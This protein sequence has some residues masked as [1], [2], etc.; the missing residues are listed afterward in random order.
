MPPVLQK[1]QE[2]ERQL[3]QHPPVFL[4]WPAVLAPLGQGSQVVSRLTASGHESDSGERVNASGH[5]DLPGGQGNA[6]ADGATSSGQQTANGHGETGIDP[7]IETGLSVTESFHAATGHEKRATWTMTG[8]DALDREREEE[9]ERERRRRPRELLDHD[10]ALLSFHA[11]RSKDREPRED[12]TRGRDSEVSRGG[13]TSK[14]LSIPHVVERAVRN[15][16]RQ[17]RQRRGKGESAA[18]GQLPLHPLPKEKE[19]QERAPDDCP[20]ALPPLSL[21]LDRAGGEEAPLDTT[22]GA[23]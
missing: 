16:E 4:V 1:Q 23:P 18:S 21:D 7:R 11:P 10:L 14:S 8:V 17:P 13:E 5:S 12:N 19:K 3:P 22:Q 6:F 15:G 20:E 2:A 9:R